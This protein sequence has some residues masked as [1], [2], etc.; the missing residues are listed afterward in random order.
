[1]HP[2][3]SRIKLSRSVCQWLLTDS[4]PSNFSLH[5]TFKSELTHSKFDCYAHINQFCWWEEINTF[6]RQ[7]AKSIDHIKNTVFLDVAQCGSYKNRLFGGKYCLHHQGEKNLRARNNVRSNRGFTSQKTAFFVVTAVKTSDFTHLPTGL[8]SGD[9]MCLLWG[10]NWFFISQKATFFIV[11][12][13]KTSNLHVGHMFL[14]SFSLTVVRVSERE[15]ECVCVCVCVLCALECACLT[16]DGGN[17]LLAT[18]KG[19]FLWEKCRTYKIEQELRFSCRVSWTQSAFLVQ[20][21]SREIIPN[22]LVSFAFSI[23]WTAITTICDS[24]F[25][26]Y[27]TDAGSRKDERTGVSRGHVPTHILNKENS[28]SPIVDIRNFCACTEP[29]VSL[30]LLGLLI[31]DLIFWSSKFLRNVRSHTDYM[32]LCPIRQQHSYVN[33]IATQSA[34]QARDMWRDLA[35]TCKNGKR[36]HLLWEIVMIQMKINAP[37]KLFCILAFVL[38]PVNFSC[39]PTLGVQPSVLYPVSYRHSIGCCFNVHISV[40]VGNID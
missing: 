6:G 31:F 4:H 23:G 33:C 26:G 10:T 12:A 20:R 18:R 22:S 13:V 1:M 29:P 9:V 34:F 14:H 17:S 35:G 27:F 39:K 38:Q 21:I 2:I 5:S 19:Q 24:C 40:P 30:L 37:S 32:A 15:R 8:C 28:T 7:S 11:T 25:R 3:H 36:L 16:V